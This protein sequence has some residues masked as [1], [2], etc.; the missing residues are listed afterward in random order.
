[1]PKVKMMIISADFEM[2]IKKGTVFRQIPI[3]LRNTV[4]FVAMKD[5]PGWRLMCR[6]RAVVRGVAQRVEVFVNRNKMGA[7]AS[8][9]NKYIQKVRF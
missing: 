1:M 3:G 8:G 9:Q 2:V 7:L 6:L 5:R 4:N